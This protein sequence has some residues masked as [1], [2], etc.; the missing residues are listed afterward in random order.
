[1]SMGGVDV[2]LPQDYLKDRLRRQNFS[3]M[4]PPRNQNPNLTRP[5]RG[6]RSPGRNGGNNNTAV[7]SNEPAKSLVM[8]QVKILKRGEP[9]NEA[10]APKDQP[11]IEVINDLALSTTDRFGPEPDLVPKKMTIADFYAGFGFFD[12]PPPSSVPVPAFFAKKGALTNDDP[13]AALRRILGLD[14]H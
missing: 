12:S 4:K 9:L 6:K 3:T 2:L 5:N 14:L 10:K 11:K 8:E 1:M 7:V 13:S